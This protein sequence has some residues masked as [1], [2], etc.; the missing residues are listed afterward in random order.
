MFN[1][2]HCPN[3]RKGVKYKIYFIA[4]IT[5]KEVKYKIY[6]IAMITEKE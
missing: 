3:N 5:E 6:F 1:I 2:F 4:L